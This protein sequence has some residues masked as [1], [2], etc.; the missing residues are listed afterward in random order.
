MPAALIAL[1][2]QLTQLL[3]Q[4]LAVY[5]A[6]RDT[7]RADD[8][9]VVALSDTALIVL[10]G[11][12][13]R[14]DEHGDLIPVINGLKSGPYRDFC[15]SVTDV[16]ADEAVHGLRAD[17]VLDDRVAGRGPAAPEGQPGE[18]ERGGVRPLAEGGS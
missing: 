3:P 12:D 7:A 5:K 4:I 17:H 14:R 16:A 8:P 9:A 10:M 1:L 13:G 11:E 2:P 6:I 18:R 15:F